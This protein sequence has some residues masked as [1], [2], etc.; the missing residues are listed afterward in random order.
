M[1]IVFTKHFPFGKFRALS[2]CGRM[3]L[4]DPNGAYKQGIKY[5]PVRF[6]SLV[7]HER[8][9]WEQQKE[10]GIIFFFIWYVIEWFFKLFSE[11]KAYKRLSF[12]REARFNQ[13][14]T[15]DYSVHCNDKYA[16]FRPLEK[17][18]S[19]IHRKWFNWCKFIFHSEDHYR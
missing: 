17:R 9:H 6:F 10:M 5:N 15:D 8:T 11:G 3:W 19:L 13:S 1:R 7:Q 18:G 2:F 14:F 12:E 4:K 16:I